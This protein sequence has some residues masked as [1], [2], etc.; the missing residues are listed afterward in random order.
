[1]TRARLNF[2]L[3][4]VAAIGAGWLGVALDRATGAGG[5]NEVAFSNTDGTLGQLVFILGP[6]IVALGLYFFSRDSAGPLGMTLRF[7]GRTRWLVLSAAFY[8]AVTIVALAAGAAVGAVSF[9]GEPAAF[10]GAFLTVLLV[11]L[12]KNP[13]EE[14]IFRG[15]GTRTA[16]ALGLPGVWTP[17][18]LAGAVWAAWHLPLYLVWT[19]AAGMRLVTSVSMVLYL[20]LLF[21]G[22]MLASVVYG[23]VRRRTGS[24]WPGVLMHSVANAVTTPL[25]LDGYVTFAGNSDLLFSPVPSAVLVMILTGVAGLILTGRLTKRAHQGDALVN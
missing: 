13:I 20:P 25:L 4:A 14:F 11:Q 17:H 21:A 15:Y 7:G 5:P 10:A 18:L 2:V 8:P 22:L 24:I 12:L 19:S 23:E 3:F 6:A 1:M 16:L 9:H